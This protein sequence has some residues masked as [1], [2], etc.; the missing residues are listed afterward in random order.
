ME[1]MWESLVFML[2]YIFAN[3]FLKPVVM[4]SGFRMQTL[5]ALQASL[6]GMGIV[7]VSCFCH[8]LLYLVLSLLGFFKSGRVI[9]VTVMEGGDVACPLCSV[10]LQLSFWKEKKQ[11]D[12][13]CLLELPG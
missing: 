6:E 7:G 9:L 8:L 3:V 5:H 2:Y 10:Y 4:Y 11:L 13:L 12:N 1:F